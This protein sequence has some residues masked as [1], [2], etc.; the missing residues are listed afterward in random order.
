MTAEHLERGRRGEEIAA[1]YLADLGWKILD[2][3]V[4]FRGGELDV[5]ALSGGELVVVEVRTRS[6]GW[7]Q[8]GEESVGPRKLGRL[9]RAGRRYVEARGWDGPWRIDILSVTLHPGKDASVERFEDVT[10]G[11]YLT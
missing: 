8:R 10:A 3:N 5:V 9:V 11:A 2:R 4:V 7:M 6:E 1:A